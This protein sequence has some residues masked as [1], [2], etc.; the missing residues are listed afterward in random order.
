MKTKIKLTVVPAIEEIPKPVSSWTLR[1]AP[2]GSQTK[3]LSVVH[4]ANNN[5]FSAAFALHSSY[6]LLK[7]HILSPDIYAS[8]GSDCLL[9]LTL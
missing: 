2:N 1:Q 3:M 4:E 8:F 5:K 7:T 6:H 9:S